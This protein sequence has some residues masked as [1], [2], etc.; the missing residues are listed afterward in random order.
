MKY[1]G[2]ICP[3]S[4]TKKKQH[5]LKNVALAALKKNEQA[6]REHF[7]KDSA[8]SSTDKYE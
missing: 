3:D 1:G 2:A 8:V 4:R 7:H 5:Q 6:T